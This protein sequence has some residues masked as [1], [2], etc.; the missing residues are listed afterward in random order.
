VKRFIDSFKPNPYQSIGAAED[1]IEVW[2][3][4]PRQ[5]VD[6][7]QSLADEDSEVRW[8]AVMAS[9]KCG[10]KLIHLPRGLSRRPKMKKNPLIAGF[11]NFVLPGLGYAYLAKWWG[12]MIFEIDIFATIWIFQ[13]WGEQFTFEA[14]LPIYLL[15]A[16]HAYYITAKMPEDPP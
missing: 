11:L 14:L 2:V 6:L 13:Y 3:N 5:Y 12:V 8:K 4:R 9:P 1:E 16:I 10:I 7:M 15:L